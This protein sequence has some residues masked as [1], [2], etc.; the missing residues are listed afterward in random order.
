MRCMK[1][2][3]EMPPHIHVID[4]NAVPIEKLLLLVAVLNVIKGKQKEREK[5]GVLR[6]V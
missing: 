2:K 5:S 3:N 1:T 4:R 6:A